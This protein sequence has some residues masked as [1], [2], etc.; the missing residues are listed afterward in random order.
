MVIT[1]KAYFKELL[2]NSEL[3]LSNY[4]SNYIDTG[5]IDLSALL[6]IYNYNGFLL[7]AFLL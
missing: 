7:L 6:L 3:D 4:I 1:S 2:S 5:N